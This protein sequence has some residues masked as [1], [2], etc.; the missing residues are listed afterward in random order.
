MVPTITNSIK[1][2]DEYDYN[3]STGYG[4]W[5]PQSLRDKLV[6]KTK[7][8]DSAYISTIDTFGRAMTGFSPSGGSIFGREYL[9]DQ[10]LSSNGIHY[11]NFYCDTTE[12]LNEIIS[13][14]QGTF[15]LTEQGVPQK[16]TVH[17]PVTL[18]NEKP[19]PY[20][21]MP[22]ENLVLAAAKN[23]P[24]LD[25]VIVN[26][27]TMGGEGEHADDFEYGVANLESYTYRSDFSSGNEEINGHDV[28]LSTGNINMTI[29]GSYV[30]MN[31]G[32]VR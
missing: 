4:I 28:Q 2:I 11:N 23:R 25:G 32:I 6:Q 14:I 8:L 13:D 5:P 16:I 31:K 15:E 20:L 19:S 7:K 1:V 26:V 30:K 24:A 10:S 18:I 9:T 21:I 12:K 27:I 22:G 17:D 3:G 29:Y